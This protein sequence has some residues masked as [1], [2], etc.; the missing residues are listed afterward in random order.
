MLDQ[1]SATV[2][3]IYAAGSGASAWSEALFSI[4]ELT[5]STAAVIN[6]V[7]N[8]PNV[9]PKTF[10]GSI[11]EEDVVEYVQDYMALC[12]RIAAGVAMPNANYICDY[13]I[14]SEAEIDRDP[15]MIGIPVMI[16]AIS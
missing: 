12:P 16:F 13:M 3:K 9:A 6:L 1:F 15:V 5:G 2:Q 4:E 14:L 8:G 10:V 7:P 11:A